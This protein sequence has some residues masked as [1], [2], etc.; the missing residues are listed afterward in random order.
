MEAA[1]LSRRLAAVLIADVADY[2]RLMEREEGETHVRISALLSEVVQPTIARNNGRV[3]RIVG[4][5]VLAEFPSA[6]DAV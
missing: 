6:T 4:D 3:L 1:Q 5:G 2:A